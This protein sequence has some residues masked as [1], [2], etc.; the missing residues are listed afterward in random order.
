MAL[1]LKSSTDYFYGLDSG[2]VR[3]DFLLQAICRSKH[4]KCSCDTKNLILCEEPKN[5]THFN[6][7]FMQL[8][9]CGA[10]W[11]VQGYP[12]ILAQELNSCF[13]NDFWRKGTC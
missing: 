3:V 1:L 8:K 9:R 2:S 13:T 10:I 7:G 11:W 4:Q 6:R 5:C 12:K